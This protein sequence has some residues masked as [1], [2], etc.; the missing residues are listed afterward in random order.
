MNDSVIVAR[1]VGAEPLPPPAR[2]LEPVAARERIELIDALRGLALLGILLVNM[3]WF[4]Q[5]LI[6]MLTSE[7]LFQGPADRW[8]ALAVRVL[9]EQKFYVIFSLLFGLGLSVQMRR[10][11][12]RGQPI[13]GRFALRMAVLLGFGIAH[14]LLIW[15]G[16]ILSAYAVLGL[17]LLAFRNC[18]QKTLLIWAVILLTLPTLLMAGLFGVATLA[19]GATANSPA[20]SAPASAGVPTSAPS[21][22]H[23]SDPYLHADARKAEIRREITIYSVGRFRDQFRERRAVWPIMAGLTL[24]GAPN[25]LAMFLLGL[26]IG[27]AGVLH[28]PAA[29]LPFWRWAALIGLLLGLPGNFLFA[30]LH[31]QGGS[32]Q[33]TSAT[34]GI[35]ALAATAA[36]L[37]SLGY[38]G[39]FVLAWQHAAGRSLLGFLA[40]A[41]RMP[42]T[43]Y[44]LQSVIC[45]AIFYSHGLGLYGKVG[46]AAGVAITLGVF[47]T[48]LLISHFLMR[49]FRY[50]PMEWIWRQLTYG[51][52]PTA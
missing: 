1:P 49:T 37:L 5:P 15:F 33:L 29:H 7:S 47:A 6:C 11:A 42:L 25:I 31:V 17:V 27:R 21:S 41:G 36:P 32:N 48:Q 22:V 12:Q 51:R 23:G 4:S 39:L 18:R 30:T 44:L 8:A 16:D 28:D 38:I 46:P 35:M 9:A 40:P 2:P 45:T 34:V 13:A 52:V 19:G 20:A 14:Y 26:W 43:N 24:F 10:A 3:A 50:G